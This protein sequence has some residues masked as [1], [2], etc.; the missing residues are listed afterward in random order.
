MKKAYPKEIE[1]IKRHDQFIKALHNRINAR[2][3]DQRALWRSASM[4][5]RRYYA[6]CTTHAGK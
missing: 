6:I 5:E 1:V 4:R 3:Q 2:G